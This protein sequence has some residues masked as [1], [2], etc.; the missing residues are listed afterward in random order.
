M[1]FCGAP[2]CLS[3]VCVR[4]LP[5][6]SIINQVAENQEFSFSQF[7]RPE[8]QNQHFGSLWLLLR[9]VRE[10][11]PH[12]SRPLSS[13]LLG[14]LVFLVF[15]CLHVHIGILLGGVS[16]F[17]FPL[18]IRPF[19]CQIRL[20]SEML[21]IRTSIHGFLSDKIQLITMRLISLQKPKYCCW[22]PSCDTFLTRLSLFI[23][24]AEH[25]WWETYSHY[26]FNV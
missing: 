17:K 5:W 25:T 2:G 6:Q 15:C 14:S 11:V 24:S 10:N 1:R 23:P 19:C 22:L 12:A 20:H 18:F 9:A 21:G 3:T 4:G 13:A 16:L 7:W 26:V 8:V